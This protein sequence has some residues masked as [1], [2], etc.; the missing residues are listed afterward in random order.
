MTESDARLSTG[1]PGLDAVLGGGLNRPT[2]VAIVGAPGAGKTILASQIIFHAAR[3]GLQTLV[4]TAF[5]EG[6][7]QYISHLRNLEFF[8]PTLAG[9]QNPAVHAPEPVHPRRHSTWEQH[10]THGSFDEGQGG[11]D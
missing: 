5:S 6:N 1:L 2:L 10:C 3:Q 11:L 7:D 4:L 8:D 9:R